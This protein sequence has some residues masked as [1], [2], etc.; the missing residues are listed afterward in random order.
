MSG[1]TACLSLI[2]TSMRIASFCSRGSSSFL[3]QVRA[4]FGSLMHPEAV[5][6]NSAAIASFRIDFP[7][8]FAAHTIGDAVTKRFIFDGR[9]LIFKRNLVEVKK[10]NPA[11]NDRVSGSARDD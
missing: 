1:G 6:Q 3:I 11:A 10:R 2:L 4:S 8:G 9:R 5:T 7:F